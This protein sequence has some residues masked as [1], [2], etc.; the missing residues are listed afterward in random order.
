MKKF[1][2]IVSLTLVMVMQL[3]RIRATASPCM[4]VEA[5]SQ[6][7]SLRDSVLRVFQKAR[8]IVLVMAG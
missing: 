6:L 5:T 8:G 1:V 7:R 4:S 2:G 3:R